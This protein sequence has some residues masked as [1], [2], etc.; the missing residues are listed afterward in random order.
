MFAVVGLWSM[1]P[2][3]IEA[4]RAGRAR[5]VDGV[6]RLPGLV[7]GFWTSGD[8]GGQAH[9]FIVFDALDAAEAFA[10]N[11]RANLDNQRSAG[12]ENL[13]LVVEE[14]TAHLP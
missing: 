9:T 7:A 14:V 1:S 5:I 4:Q 8:G 11:V 2:E 3:L 10:S 12:V 13:S 6:S